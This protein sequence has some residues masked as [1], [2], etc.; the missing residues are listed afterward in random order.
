MTLWVVYD[1]SPARLP[2]AVF[3]SA[4]EAAKYTGASLATVQSIASRAKHGDKYAWR[5]ARI[6]VK[7]DET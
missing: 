3:E 7:E 5:Y 1:D 2:V 6:K 4:A